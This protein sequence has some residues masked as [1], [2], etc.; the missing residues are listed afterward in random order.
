MRCAFEGMNGP[1][2]EASLSTQ[3]LSG[4]GSGTETPAVGEGQTSRPQGTVAACSEGLP[5]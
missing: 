1:S 5:V 4:L 2:P 3:T